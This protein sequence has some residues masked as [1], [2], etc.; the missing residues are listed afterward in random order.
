MNDDINRSAGHTPSRPGAHVDEY[1]HVRAE[2]LLLGGDPPQIHITHAKRQA[3]RYVPILPEPARQNWHAAYRRRRNLD[4]DAA[5]TG[6]R[7]PEYFFPTTNR[8]TG[9][10]HF[11]SE[12]PLPA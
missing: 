12:G 8:T 3:D 10:A 1:V 5:S 4:E 9:R 11:L 6:G 7:F 2:D